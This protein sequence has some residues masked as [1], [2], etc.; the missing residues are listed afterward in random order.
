MIKKHL[1]TVLLALSISLSNAQIVTKESTINT[2]ETA[3][4]AAEQKLENLKPDNEA[5][6]I[7][8]KDFKEKQSPIAFVYLHG[9]GASNREGQPIMSMLSKTYNA[10]VYLSRLKEHGLNREDNFKNLTP[11]NYIASAKEALE[12]GKIIGKQVILVSTSTGGTLSLKL[13]AEDPSIAGLIMYSPFID[14]KNPAF[15]SILTPE[16]KAGFIK[17]NGGEIMKQNRPKKEQKYWSTSYHID[18]YEALI[19]MLKSTMTAQTFEKVTVPVFVGYYYKSEKEQDEVVSVP[20]IL[21]MYESLGTAPD[22]KIKVAFP[23]A[24]NHV[25]ACDLRSNDLK[26]VFDKTTSFIDGVILK[27]E[28]KFGFELQGHRGARGLAPENTLPAFKKALDLGVNTLELDVVISEDNQVVVSHEPWLNYEIT[29]DAK[30]KNITKEDALAFNIYKNKY[31]TIKKY[32]VGAI[33]NPK[34]PE[35]E[36]LKTYKPLLAEVIK[37]AETRN[38]AIFYNIEIKSTP[39]EEANGFQPS[40]KDFSDLLISELKKS[41]LPLNRITIQSFDPRVLEYLHKTYPDYQLSFLT[42]ENDFETNMK[43]LTFIPEIYSPY[44]VLL[45]DIEVENIHQK[46][47]KVI[48]WT[49]NNKEDMVRLL[50][51]NVDG[52]I[53]DYPNIGIPL[54]K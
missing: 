15:A 38:P 31:K 2:I 6:I 50:T 51:M 26:N 20:A 5:R 45:N 22:K 17:M 35:Q 12:I 36:K 42:F 48:P 46:N 37:Y 28:R 10:N 18:G 1:L 11:E 14:L 8:A 39:E 3:I 33:G 52:I 44:Y 16:G 25:I 34:F 21:K 13:A 9:F 27:K 19:K 54:R 53:T 29:L 23:E 32:D 4:N 30:G 40:V 49:V 7:W 43:A 47:M 24:G 41:N